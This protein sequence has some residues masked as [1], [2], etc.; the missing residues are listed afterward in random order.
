[1][2][3]SRRCSG[4][5]SFTG[6]SR[7]CGS[8]S[9]PETTGSGCSRSRASTCRRASSS[10]KSAGASAGSPKE[11][12]RPPGR[13]RSTLRGDPYP[14]RASPGVARSPP[15]GQGGG[16]GRGMARRAA[17]DAPRRALG[18]FELDLDALMAPPGADP[19]R[20]RHHL[21]RE[22]AGHSS[23]GRRGR[24][25][26]ARRRARE[27]AGPELREVRPSTSTAASRSATGG[28]RSRCT[29][30]SSRRSGRSATTRSRCSG[31]GSSPL[32]ER[33]DAELRS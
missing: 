4:R 2:S 9:T 17:P 25:G 29:S 1:M 8:T 11:A 20:R 7:R 21:P 26:G 23:R 33:F 13:R 3:A 32:G 14:A 10:L 12:S 5:R 22:P 27:A 15:S 19:L 6:L 31:T 18:A 24:R 16:D 30:C 28:S